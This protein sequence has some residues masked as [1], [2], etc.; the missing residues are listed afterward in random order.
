MRLR[1]LLHERA[2]ILINRN[3]LRPGGRLD[4]VLQR[5]VDAG[6]EL[7][8]LFPWA[9]TQIPLSRPQSTIPD[10]SDERY[11]PG[12]N[13][14]PGRGSLLGYEAIADPWNRVDVVRLLGVTLDLLAQVG[15]HPG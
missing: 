13:K 11:M 4:I 10:C 14:G 5:R 6:N 8:H 2:R 15:A 12:P 9:A 7:R 1:H 3:T